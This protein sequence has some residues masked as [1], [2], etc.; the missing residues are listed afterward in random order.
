MTAY[1][2]TV[3]GGIQTLLPYANPHSNLDYPCVYLST[4]KALASIYIWNKAYKW[5]TFEIRGDGVP[6]YNESF[7]HGLREF[8]AGVKG[9]IYTCHADFETDANTTIQHAVI[10]KTPVEISDVDVVEDACERILAYEQ[11]GLLVINRF[12]DRSEAQKS[13]DNNMIL[14]AI[15]RFDLLQ[16]DHPL[17]GFVSSKFPQL[18]NEALCAAQLADPSKNET[19]IQLENGVRL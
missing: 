12:E 17:S 19:I 2:G 4:N 7:E 15:R 5:M 9:Y 11:K 10:S 16:G 14:A 8:Y 13:K 1:H 6:V 3:V 18:W